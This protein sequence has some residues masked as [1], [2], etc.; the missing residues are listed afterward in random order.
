MTTAFAVAAALVAVGAARA[1]D[2]RG[3]LALRAGLELRL[4]ELLLLL[5]LLRALLL[6]RLPLL[7]A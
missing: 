5:M 4:A 1:A 6:P 3:F 7:L 2:R